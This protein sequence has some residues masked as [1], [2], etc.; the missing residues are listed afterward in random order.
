LLIIKYMMNPHA[1]GYVEYGV[2]SV[3][4]NLGIM[5]CAIVLWFSQRTESDYEYSLT[6]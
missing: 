1:V 3:L 5:A 2:A 4:Q 6:L